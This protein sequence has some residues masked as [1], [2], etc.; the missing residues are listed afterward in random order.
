MFGLVTD[1]TSINVFYRKKLADKGWSNLTVEE[2]AEWLGNPLDASGANLFACGPFYSSAVDLKY[3][4]EEIVATAVEAGTY[5]YAVS[6]IGKASD[7]ANRVFTLSADSIVASATGT[8]QLAVYW[9]DD[10]GYE[11]AGASLLSAGS[12][13][14]DTGE[15]PNTSGREYLAVYVY[16]TT[17]A[18]VEVGETVRFGHVMLEA[19]EEAH[20]YVPYTEILPTVATKGAYNYSDLNRVE[21]VV[22][23]FSEREGLNLETKTNWGPWEI[24]TESDMSLYLGNIA[25]IRKRLASSTSVPATPSSMSNFTY[26]QANNIE[27]ILNAAMERITNGN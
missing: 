2:R 7:Y 21:R 24:P 26:E 18:A 9:H 10:N 5:L 8:P 20:E 23:E 11:F 14:F 3:R 4:R 1:R 19:G 13:T 27:I 16:V 15:W 17:Y 22:A 25:A 12:V 6:I